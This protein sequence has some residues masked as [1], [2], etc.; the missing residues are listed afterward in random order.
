MQLPALHSIL[1]GQING[2]KCI[3]RHLLCGIALIKLERD[4]NCC[5]PWYDPFMAI[6]SVGIKP[7]WAVHAGLEDSSPPHPRPQAIGHPAPGACWLPQVMAGRW[8]QL[9]GHHSCG[10]CCTAMPQHAWA[11]SEDQHFHHRFDQCCGCHTFLPNRLLPGVSLRNAFVPVYI[12]ALSV[13]CFVTFCTCRLSPCTIV[14][15]IPLFV[16]LEA[17]D[18]VG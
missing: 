11:I 16:L 17:C 15:S 13:I 3:A 1:A 4:Q 10:S 2:V 8:L 7:S 6:R 14:P 18:I 12:A 9:E 5:C